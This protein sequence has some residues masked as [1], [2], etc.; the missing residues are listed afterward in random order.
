MISEIFKKLAEGFSLASLLFLSFITQ[1]F[2]KISANFVVF[3]ASLSFY[4]SATRSFSPSLKSELSP[5]LDQQLEIQ[6]TL[7]R[8]LVRRYYI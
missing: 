7:S 8:A 5:V 4:V 1:N 2:R 6:I 3:V